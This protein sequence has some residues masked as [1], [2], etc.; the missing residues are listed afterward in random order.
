MRDVIEMFVNGC[1]GARRVSRADY[2][3]RLATPRGWGISPDPRKHLTQHVRQLSADFS[4][5][6]FLPKEDFYCVFLR[7]RT[8]YVY[9]EKK[10]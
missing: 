2:L 4:G 1:R 8:V 7:F 10:K 3:S 5:F 6:A 9:Y